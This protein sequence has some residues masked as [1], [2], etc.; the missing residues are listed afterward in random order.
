M[1]ETPT[2]VPA[3]EGRIGPTLAESEPCFAEP[4]IPARMRPMS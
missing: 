2:P 4:L 1:T 3:F